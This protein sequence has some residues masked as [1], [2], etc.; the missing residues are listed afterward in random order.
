LALNGLSF[1][2]TD[3][4]FQN[5][6]PL[7]NIGYVRC[8]KGC[9]EKISTTARFSLLA[10]RDNVPQNEP[11]YKT[12]TR[13]TDS[14]RMSYFFFVIALTAVLAVAVQGNQGA[15]FPLKQ[16]LEC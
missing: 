8:K 2:P 14:S 9:R 3:Q 7:L 15:A 10:F 13:S 12:V 5:F 6:F 1:K 4:H 16:P 11:K